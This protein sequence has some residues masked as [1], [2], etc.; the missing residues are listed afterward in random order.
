MTR[1]PFHRRMVFHCVCVLHFLSFTEG[2]LGWLHILPIMHNSSVNMGCSLLWH[3]AFKSFG[4]KPRRDWAGSCGNFGFLRSLHTVS[5]KGCAYL[6][7]HPQYVKCS[8]FSSNL[9]CKGHRKKW[10]QTQGVSWAP[11]LQQPVHTPSLP[12]T[13]LPPHTTAPSDELT[14]LGAL[15]QWFCI[16][17]TFVCCL[18]GYFYVHF[19]FSS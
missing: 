2:H 16:L 7:S 18:P 19:I 4:C 9:S 14:D 3:A 11:F 10:A 12:D 1:L 6:Y 8:L 5:Y 13:L 15:C 17:C